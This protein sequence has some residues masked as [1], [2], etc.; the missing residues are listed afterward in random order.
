VRRVEQELGMAMET[1]QRVEVMGHGAIVFEGTPDD[2]RANAAVRKEW[3][4]V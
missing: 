1:S 2:L 4:E 3:L